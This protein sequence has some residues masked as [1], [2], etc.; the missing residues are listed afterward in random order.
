MTS[1]VLSL[2]KSRRSASFNTSTSCAYP[3]PFADR[4]SPLRR[5]HHRRYRCIRIRAHGAPLCIAHIQ[6]YFSRHRLWNLI[7]F[8]NL[9]CWLEWFDEIESKVTP[10]KKLHTPH[11]SI[12]ALETFVMYINAKL[13]KKIKNG[14]IAMVLKRFDLCWC[15][16]F[17]V[18]NSSIL[19]RY[20]KSFFDFSSSITAMMYVSERCV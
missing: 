6:S 8:C 16:S 17:W 5:I 19:R 20:F 3:S 4:R 1:S 12:S 14:K 11:D 18:F 13:R 10:I 9:R 15:F 2:D 7:L